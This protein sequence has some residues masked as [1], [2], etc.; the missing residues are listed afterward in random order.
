MLSE[1][2]DRIIHDTSW[3][4]KSRFAKSSRRRRIAAGSGNSFVE[5]K[6]IKDFAKPNRWCKA[7]SLVLWEDDETNGGSIQITC[8]KVCLVGCRCLP[9]RHDGTRWHAWLVSCR[10]SAGMPWYRPS[11]GGGLKGRAVN[12]WWNGRWTKWP[13]KC[14]KIRKNGNNRFLIRA[15]NTLFWVLFRNYLEGKMLKET[16]ST[17]HSFSLQDCFLRTESPLNFPKGS[18]KPPIRPIIFCTWG[19]R[20]VYSD[21]TEPSTCSFS[22]KKTESLKN[23]SQ[24]DDSYRDGRKTEYERAEPDGCDWLRE[25]SRWLTAWPNRIP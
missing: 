5:N 24:Q 14:A 23:K 19:V 6:F 11:A 20:P 22:E 15:W 16:I 8:R 4:G 3:T 12:L 25:Q 13:N 10:R 1:T 7:S 2:C 18:K 17:S 21:S 9:S